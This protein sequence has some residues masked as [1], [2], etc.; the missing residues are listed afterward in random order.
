MST[1]TYSSSSLYFNTPFDSRGWLG[2][3]QPRPI[4]IAASDQQ[5]TIS[6]VYNYRPDLMA[7]DLYGDARLWWVFAQRNP[8][9][10][11]ADPL[12]NFVTGLKIYIPQAAAL[13]QLLGL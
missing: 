12:G 3:W 10:L 6:N 11:A 13:K 9:A 7:H 1:P 2:I 8:N 5:V 4:P